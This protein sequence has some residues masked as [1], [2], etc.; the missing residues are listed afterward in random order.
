MKHKE[1]RKF[2]HKEF[3]QTK[4]KGKGHTTGIHKELS[5]T[6]YIKDEIEK[7]VY[8]LIEDKIMEPSFSES[9]RKKEILNKLKNS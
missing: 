6:S 2:L 1:K 5:H 3:L 9:Q 7:Q 4:L 8:K